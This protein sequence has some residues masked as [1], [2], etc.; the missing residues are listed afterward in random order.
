VSGEDQRS[1]EDRD[2]HATPEKRLDRHFRVCRILESGARAL[3]PG[4]LLPRGCFLR[5]ES[6]AISSPSMVI[7][8]PTAM[9]ATPSPGTGPSAKTPSASTPIPAQ[10]SSPS[11]VPTDRLRSSPIK[12]N[13]PE[14]SIVTLMETLVHQETPGHDCNPTGE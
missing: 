2:R 7:Q 6:T 3:P 14:S 9:S 11:R 5:R 12:V 8:N 10:G 1:S 4:P 13:L